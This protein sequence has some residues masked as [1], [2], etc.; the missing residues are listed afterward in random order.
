M[1]LPKVS[2]GLQQQAGTGRVSLL[3]WPEGEPRIR[4][5]AGAALLRPDL[6]TETGARLRTPLLAPVPPRPVSPVPQDGSEH[7]LLRQGPTHGQALQLSPLVVWEALREAALVHPAQVRAHLP[8][9]RLQALPT[10]K[11]ADLLVWSIENRQTLCRPNV[12]VPK[13]LW[14]AAVVRTAQV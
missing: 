10:K 11:P 7:L 6:L 8:L 1:A 2:Q 13:S 14:Q 5:L 9:R 4:P 3:L 12:A